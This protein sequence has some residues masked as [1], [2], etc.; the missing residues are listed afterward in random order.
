RISR[1]IQQVAFVV[2]ELRDLFRIIAVYRL[3]WAAE[4]EGVVGVVF[5]FRGNRV[6]H[7]PGLLHPHAAV[8]RVVVI[9]RGP[10]RV[11]G[12]QRA[13]VIA[14]LDIA[15]NQIIGGIVGIFKFD[16]AE[17]KAEGSRTGLNELIQRVVG[18]EPVIGARV[19]AAGQ[20]AA[21]II[22]VAAANEGW[23][24]G[25]NGPIAQIAGLRATGVI[26][27]H[28][29]TTPAVCVGGVGNGGQLTESVVGEVKHP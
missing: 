22:F 16:A 15:L 7:I 24:L 18:V 19:N 11:G 3:A 25:V 13:G 9:N 12:I 29:H 20:V 23:A 17:A 4:N 2:G 21:R 6:R 1:L 27:G 8:E 26:V 10:E 28:I 14:I 5:I